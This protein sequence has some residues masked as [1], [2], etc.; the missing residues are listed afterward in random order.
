M[1][2][3]LNYSG[4]YFYSLV[5]SICAFTLLAQM[6][7]E[8][9]WYILIEDK[10]HKEVYPVVGNSIPLLPIQLLLGHSFLSSPVL[11]L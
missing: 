4:S 7:L 11:H 5:L 6:D 10:T 3:F 1:V 2:L 9:C 8:E